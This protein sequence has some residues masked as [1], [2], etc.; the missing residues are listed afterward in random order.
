[1]KPAASDLTDEGIV[2]GL[3]CHDENITRT[4][5]YGICRVAYHHY[6]PL[7][8]LERQGYDFYT[9]AH[10]YYLSL[11]LKGWEPLQ[12]RRPQVS[13]STWMVRG[14]LYVALECLRRGNRREQRF[15]RLLRDTELGFDLPDP[16]ATDSLAATL[17]EL[18]D[19]TGLSGTDRRILTGIVVEGYLGKELARELGITPSA[20][21]QRY[22]RLMDEVVVP[23][24]KHL[25][26]VPV[27]QEASFLAKP[28]LCCEAEPVGDSKS[29]RARPASLFGEAMPMHRRVAP[30]RTIW[31]YESNLDGLH[32]S[33]SA[34]TAVERYGAVEGV[35][36]GPQ[37]DSY[38]IPAMQGGPDTLR[39]YVDGFIAHA[40]SHRDC[41]F[42]VAPVGCELAGF[43][44]AEVAPLFVAAHPLD[45]VILTYP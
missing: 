41:L 37:G 31:V 12:R 36:V 14:F 3:R 32:I 11:E 33:P 35:G 39:P 18:C 38:G 28:R 6:D 34:R 44:P 13:L 29:L 24:F 2:A 20:V 27:A 8:G 5:F 30:R 42:H 45:N 15:D 19:H 22:R 23:Y 7:Y 43:D 26:F 4:Y 9:L 17:D 1:M 25:Y 21:S 16:A 40:R 10:D